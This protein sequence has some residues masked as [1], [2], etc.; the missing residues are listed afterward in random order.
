MFDIAALS[1]ELRRAADPRKREWWERYLKGAIDFYGAP[2]AAIRR[3]VRDWAGADFDPAELRAASLELLEQPIAEQKLAG[4]LIMQE[5]LLPIGAVSARRDL[6]LIAR[7]FDEGH[8]ADWNTT[9]WLCVRVLGPLIRQDGR[10]TAEALAAWARSAPGLWRRRAGAVAF[11]PVAGG[12]DELFAGLVDLIIDVCDHMAPD[13]A[14]FNQTA[15]GWVMRDLSDAAP[16]RVYGFL[17]SHRAVLSREAVRMAAARLSDER[18]AALGIT[19][20]RR[21]R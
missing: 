2:M 1:A 12:G 7:V 11:V 3:A 14:R 18:R 21:R 9:D 15:I 16:D 19:G 5:L 8:I 13:T 6:P 20:K 4:I 10:P 17:E